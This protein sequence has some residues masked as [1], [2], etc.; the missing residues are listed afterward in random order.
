MAF[1]EQGQAVT[2][3]RK[4][5]ICKRSYDILTTRCGF[6]PQDIIFDPN[7]LTIATGIEEHNNYAVEFINAVKMI[8]AAMPLTHVSGGVSNLSFS[9][10]GNDHIREAM[11]SAF[12]YHAINNGMEMGIVNAGALPIYSDIE[13]T[14][15]QL[16]EDAILNR[17]PD[18]TE[19]LLEFAQKTKQAAGGAKA[20]QV[21]EWRSKPTEEKLTY[22]LV[23]GIDTYINEDTEEARAA[24]SILLAFSNHSYDPIRKFWGIWGPRY[25]FA[26]YIINRIIS[27]HLKFIQTKEL[28]ESPTEHFAR[29]LA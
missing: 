1:D 20:A 2:A 11:H 25:K 19:K 21:E 17:T 27:S 24:V 13:P 6:A 5:E 12:L 3:D 7:I 16:V 26:Y 28:R 29:I 9:F 15:L 23:K 22:S 10:R 14:L 18:A 4:F 8:K